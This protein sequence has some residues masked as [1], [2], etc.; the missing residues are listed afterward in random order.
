[1]AKYLSKKHGKGRAAVK[2]D[3][4][5]AFDSIRWP[6][7]QATLEAMNFSP[8]WVQWIMA[9]IQSH[10][11]S[12]LING[13][14][15][16][17]F[18][19]SSGLRQ[20]DPISPML[21]VL[22]MEFFSQSLDAELTQGK[23]GS[24]TKHSS[25]I[26]HLLFVDDLLIFTP[27]TRRSGHALRM[28]LSQFATLSGLELNSG[29]TAVTYLGRPLVMGALT[30]RLCLPLVDK[31]RKRLQCWHGHMLSL[32]GGLELANS[33]LFSLQLYWSS[34]FALPQ[35]NIKAMEKA[36]RSFLWGGPS[37]KRSLHHVNWKIVCLPK[38]E[39]WPGLKRIGD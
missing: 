9:C 11:F 27:I 26:S 8:I 1:M 14:P 33:V 39:G 31:L 12:V 35:G 37:L 5:K 28:L 38:G 13:S 17:F 2:I 20:G 18:E 30:S 7:I 10:R 6:F 3:L 4:R 21:F 29:V 19:S 34:A 22:G 15:F 16:G 36:I 32:A 24:F 25:A 23:I